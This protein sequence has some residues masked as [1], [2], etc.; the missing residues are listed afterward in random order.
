MANKKTIRK[1]L[2][3]SLGRTAS[4]EREMEKNLKKR[5]KIFAEHEKQKLGNQK[6][7]TDKFI[8]KC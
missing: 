8:A 6:E 3:N 1:Q 5:G 4:E 2:V 7:R